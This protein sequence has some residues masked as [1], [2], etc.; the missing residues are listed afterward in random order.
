MF[1]LPDIIAGYQ[2]VT[3]QTSETIACM[4]SGRKNVILRSPRSTQD[5]FLNSKDSL[6][7]V[8]ELN[9]TEIGSFTY[10]IIGPSVSDLDIE[11]IFNDSNPKLQKNPCVKLVSATNPTLSPS[12]IPASS[13]SGAPGFVHFVNQDAGLYPNVNGQNDN[14]QSVWL[15]VPV[16]TGPLPFNDYVAFL[17]NVWTDQGA[18]YQVGF[19]AN[20]FSF[21]TLNVDY[22]FSVNGNQPLGTQLMTTYPGN[23]Y[24]FT[25]SY[26]NAEWW[27]CG[28]VIN[29]PATYTCQS[30]HQTN[31]GTNLGPNI[32]TG[33]FLETHTQDPNWYNA[34]TGSPQFHTGQAKIYL[35]G[36]A[37][38]WVNGYQYFQPLCNNPNATHN[39]PQPMSG[40]LN[41][42]G[43]LTFQLTDAALQCP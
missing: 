30:D 39:P 21:T 13:G 12:M 33:V 16:M 14:A 23:I 3:V 37:Q 10:Q 7:I 22:G 26:T 18:F 43:Y 1:G 29:N 24:R 5:S 11:K 28:E 20:N 27:M 2:V 36:F 25:I 34:F 6:L 40:S 17:N 35:N 38:P 32:N 8:Q 15:Y 9:K 31:R 42:A 4:E 19:V 41:N